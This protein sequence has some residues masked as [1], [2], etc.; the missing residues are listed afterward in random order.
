MMKLFS[1]FLS[2]NILKNSKRFHYVIKSES[3]FRYK[4][5]SFYTRSYNEFEITFR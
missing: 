2:K 5:N 3:F 4:R 1:H